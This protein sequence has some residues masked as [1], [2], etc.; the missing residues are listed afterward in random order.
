MHYSYINIIT[1]RK[2]NWFLYI[3]WNISFIVKHAHECISARARLRICAYVRMCV[4]AF[5]RTYICVPVYLCMGSTLL[6]VWV[7]V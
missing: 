4:C 5:A 6:K 3:F 2:N 7:C 1:V